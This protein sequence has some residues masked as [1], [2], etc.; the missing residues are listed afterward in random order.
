M[1]AG[2]KSGLP[3]PEVFS[4]PLDGECGWSNCWNSSIAA[5]SS[6]VGPG[7]DA[8]RSNDFNQPLLG[9]AAEP[10]RV[11]DVP[12]RDEFINAGFSGLM[13]VEDQMFGFIRSSWPSDNP[14]RAAESFPPS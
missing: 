10:A 4:V 2:E 6:G 13:L 14:Q 1:D 12:F 3:N 7:D 11:S 8:G 5:F 9:A